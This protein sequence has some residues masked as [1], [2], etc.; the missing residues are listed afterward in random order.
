MELL[1]SPAWHSG[2][3]RRSDVKRAVGKCSLVEYNKA[4]RPW[5]QKLDTLAYR[6]IKTA[7][8]KLRRNYKNRLYQ[9]KSR[10]NARVVPSAC[11]DHPVHAMHER[12]L[13]ARF[14]SGWKSWH[15]QSLAWDRVTLQ[16]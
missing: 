10:T 16:F 8:S 14:V 13:D 1:A 2:S 5:E 4:L 15:Q 3:P 9:A 12:Q 6:N 7:A 11:M